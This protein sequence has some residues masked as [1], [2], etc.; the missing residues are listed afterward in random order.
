LS[1][2]GGVIGIG[3][4]LGIG[5]LVQALTPIPAAV[6]VWTVF[7]GLIFC[8]VVGLVFGVYPATKAAKMDPI[9]ALR[10]E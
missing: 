2:V 1:E 4:G 7:L 5:K 8:S 6:P 3:L 9:V 10:Y